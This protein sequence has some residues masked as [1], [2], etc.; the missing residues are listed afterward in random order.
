MGVFEPLEGC[1]GT[2]KNRLAQTYY[3]ATRKLT[4]WFTVVEKGGLS[5]FD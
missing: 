3:N 2:L 1:S 5:F 4:K